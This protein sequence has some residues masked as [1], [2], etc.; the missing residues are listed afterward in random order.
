MILEGYT[1]IYKG[2]G[3]IAILGALWLFYRGAVDNAYQNGYDQSTKDTDK[4][5]QGLI[6]EQSRQ[7]AI[8][9][10]NLSEDYKRRTERLVGQNNDEWQ[11]RYDVLNT[12]LI[13]ARDAAKK[14]GA[15]KNDAINLDRSV[16]A[17]AVKLLN[18]SKNIVSA[19]ALANRI[20]ESID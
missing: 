11:R 19:P 10:K 5:Y 15:I 12:D 9:L 3:G 8:K 2:M 17:N 13:Q 1:A 20:T 4:S 18:E 16:S 14:L 7:Q 6:A